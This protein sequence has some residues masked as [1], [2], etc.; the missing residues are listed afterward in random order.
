MIDI[1]RIPEGRKAV[2]IGPEG[3]TKR[4]IE[5]QTRTKLTVR[6]GVTI[7]GQDG[8]DVYTAAQVVKA[9][10]RGFAPEQAFLLLD[11]EAQLHVITLREH[12]ERMRKTMTA[13][14]VGS[15]GRAKKLIE[16]YTGCAMAVYGKTVAL[17][18]TPAQLRSAAEAVDAILN[19]R[20][21]SFVFHGLEKRAKEKDPL[22]ED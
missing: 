5:E 13:R 1:V 12:S 20:S 21:H 2:L 19:G 6:D 3:R 4:S 14:L 15:G 10:G 11:E 7:E 22:G 16:K 9:I 18:G 17:I 8:L